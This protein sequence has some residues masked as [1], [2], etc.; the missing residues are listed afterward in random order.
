[1]Q[2]I[3]SMAQIEIDHLVQRI[4]ST[5]TYWDH[6]ND[7]MNGKYSEQNMLTH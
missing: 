2:R 3:Y 1:M 5:Y 4:Y 7:Q 6:P